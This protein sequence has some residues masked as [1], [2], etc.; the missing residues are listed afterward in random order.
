[1]ADCP[2]LSFKRLVL[3]AH[4]A[5]MVDGG[6]RCSS[7]QGAGFPLFSPLL[8]DPRRWLSSALVAA[9]QDSVDIGATWS[10]WRRWLQPA[11]LGAACEAILRRWNAA[12][13]CWFSSDGAV[14]ASSLR[15]CR[16]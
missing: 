14:V 3:A 8:F 12:N 1:M 2:L 9:P 6:G 15:L 16:R 10:R 7:I 5:C 11:P 4:Q 13:A